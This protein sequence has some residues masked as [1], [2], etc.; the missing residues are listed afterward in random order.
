MFGNTNDGVN[1]N[2]G[3]RQS[4]EGK[5]AGRGGVPERAS[6]GNALKF[7]ADLAGTLR[8]TAG[9]HETTVIRALLLGSLVPTRSERTIGSDEWQWSFKTR[10]LHASFHSDLNFLYLQAQGRANVSIPSYLWLTLTILVTFH[11]CELSAVSR[12]RVSVRVGS[13]SAASVS[14]QAL[15]SGLLRPARSRAP[16]RPALI[17]MSLTHVHLRVS[18]MWL[19]LHVYTLA[20]FDPERQRETPGTREAGCFTPAGRRRFIRN[21]EPPRRPIASILM[22]V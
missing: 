21:G 17:S 13:V 9:K 2:E 10:P 8:S 4:V 6:R 7:R 1:E 15:I 22:G 20:A 18:D 14:S 5:A 11:H 3:E 16:S 19:M 12:R